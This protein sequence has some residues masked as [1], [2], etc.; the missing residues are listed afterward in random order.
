MGVHAPRRVFF[1]SFKRGIEK[2]K[3]EE[4]GEKKSK[5]YNGI[6]TT[7]PRPIFA[8][9]VEVPYA[10]AGGRP[11]GMPGLVT[12]VGKDTEPSDFEQNGRTHRLPSILTRLG[13]PLPAG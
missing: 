10:G 11:K 2:K 1:E 9:E 8:V 5:R 4:N 13:G 3:K 7:L 6:P 12:F